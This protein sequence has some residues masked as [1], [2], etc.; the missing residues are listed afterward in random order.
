MCDIN[1]INLAAAWYFLSAQRT[2]KTQTV[3]QPMTYVKHGQCARTKH[4]QCAPSSHAATSPS[5]FYPRFCNNSQTL[6]LSTSATWTTILE[7]KPKISPLGKALQNSSFGVKAPCKR[8]LEIPFTWVN[9]Q[10]KNI[11]P[12]D[13]AVASTGAKDAQVS[14]REASY[15]LLGLKKCI[16]EWRTVHVATLCLCDKGSNAVFFSA[17]HLSNPWSG[18]R[19]ACMR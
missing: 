19:Q 12:P 16:R 10:A 7:P 4:H 6:N 9:K 11:M 5:H 3:L 2:M 14:S 1:L 17:G 8:S 15:L 18:P 13:M